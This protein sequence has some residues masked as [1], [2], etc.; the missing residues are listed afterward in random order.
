MIYQRKNPH[1]HS[2]RAGG[3]GGWGECLASPMREMLFSWLR[4]TIDRRGGGGGG[5]SRY[6]RA[7]RLS[8]SYH[9]RPESV[10]AKRS[11]AQRRVALW[12]FE[13]LAATPHCPPTPSHTSF[14]RI[15]VR[16]D[17]YPPPHSFLGFTL[18]LFVL[19]IQ[20]CVCVCVQTPRRQVIR[21]RRK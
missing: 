12:S 16:G 14:Q 10:R 9:V 19:Y 15:I 1:P 2:P 5:P 21:G 13:P 3:G 18:P 7:A 6:L 11:N 4:H 20:L 8:G 17:L